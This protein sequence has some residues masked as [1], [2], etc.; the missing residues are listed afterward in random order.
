MTKQEKINKACS[1]LEESSKITTGFYSTK[2]YTSQTLS[3]FV[4]TVTTDSISTSLDNNIDWSQYLNTTSTNI[5]GNLSGNNNVNKAIGNKKTTSG[6]SN[7]AI[8]NG[9]TI[10]TTGVN[11]TAIGKSALTNNSTSTANTITINSNGNVGL[12]TSTIG[13]VYN[14]G[15][16]TYNMSNKYTL[17]GEEVEL[18]YNY[19]ND[20][21]VALIDTLGL[22]FWD[23]Y[24]KNSGDAHYVTEMDKALRKFRRNEK[25]DDLLNE[26]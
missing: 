2:T 7:I 21:I 16:F 3:P 9:T 8:G 17:F 25:I 5:V 22:E 13:T 6:L 23:N 26:C 20:L 12:G 18:P 14:T 19:Q 24:K 4:T 11:N 15:S 1:L 10:T